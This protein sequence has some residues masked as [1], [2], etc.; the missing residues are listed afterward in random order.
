M[1]PQSIFRLFTIALTLV[2][3]G[4]V[5][6]QDD[7][8]TT[9]FNLETTELVFPAEGG[10][11]AMEL[12]AGSPWTVTCDRD[13]CLV[14]PIN[15]TSSTIC[16]IRVDSSYLYTDREAH[17]NFRCG[18]LSRQLT[19]RQ[20][21][22]QKVIR[23]SKSQ[24]EVPDFT[25]F[26]QLFEE[27]TVE[28]NV[29][30]DIQVEYTDPD[31]T[32]WLHPSI[33]HSTQVQSIPRPARVRLD[34]DLYISSDQ[35]RLATVVFR[36]K[37]APAGETPVESRLSFRQK[38][39]QEIIPSREG[40]SLALVT[41]SRMMHLESKWDTSTPMIYWNN[42]TLEPIT[43]YNTRLQQT[44][45][46]PRVTR[47]SFSLFNT[48]EGIPFHI[49]YLDQLRHLSYTANANAHIKRIQLGDYVTQLKHLKT[50]SLIGY[51]ITDL[52]ESM[53]NMTELEVLELSGNNFT[54][55][56]VDVITALDRHKL[57]Y[58]NLAN[59]RRRDVYAKLNEYA[60]V[61]DTLGIHGE[62]PAA[63]FCLKNVAYLGL[64]YNYLEGSIPNMDYDASQYATLEEK[65]AHNPVMPQ[66]E[67][68][69]LNLNYFTGELPDWV[70]Y[71]R[72]LRC[73][74]PYT[75]LFNQYEG[76]R[77]SYWRKTGFT[78]EPS[79]IQQ[80]CPLWYDDDAEETQQNETYTLSHP[81]NRANTFDAGFWYNTYQGAQR[82]DIAK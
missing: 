43:Y 72:N 79:F 53:A 18:S 29:A 47:V 11:Y 80:S 19:I 69:S 64:S 57:W 4:L 16:Q 26:E 21:G 32:G 61:R 14:N 23:L 34:Y 58:V 62:L 13:W 52:P 65:I 38:H 35:D 51:G 5:S 36:E 74:D 48:N 1:T 7:E 12:S 70:L 63:L 66:L 17:L 6:C 60:D 67:Q 8:V 81:F 31:R 75:L 37:D 42:V 44:I 33:K 10:S 73:W 40:D 71:H 50:L 55:I 24:I 39:A 28:S 78:N 30:Y 15:G 77:D 20:F 59:N 82:R 2:T 27:I 49:T 68:L 45:T 54:Q 9:S 3:L 25:D 22:F 46:E 56:P 76:S 41:I